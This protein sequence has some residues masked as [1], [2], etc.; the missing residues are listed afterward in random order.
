MLSSPAN[1]RLDSSTDKIRFLHIAK[2]LLMLLYYVASAFFALKKQPVLTTLMVSTL[3][4][5]IGG[6]VTTLAMLR[7]LGG[8]PIPAKSASLH[9][10]RM[11]PAPLNGRTGS[12]ARF[13]AL[14]TYQNALALLSAAKGV[15]QAVV[16]LTPLRV[17]VQSPALRRVFVDG[18]ITTS[19]F[20]TM[21]NAP[22]RYGSTWTKDD[23]TR[24]SRIV[25]LSSALNDRL[26]SGED[27]VG[28]TVALNGIDYRVTGVLHPWSPQPR[29]YGLQL[30]RQSFGESDGAYLPL[31]TALSDAM[32]PEVISCFGAGNVDSLKS[33]PCQ[34]LGFWVETDGKAGESAYREYL[35]NFVGNEVHAGRMERA[36]SELTTLKGWL[37]EN[38]V[39]SDD[40]QLQ[41]GLAIGFLLICIVNTSGLLLAKQLSRSSEFGIRRALGAPK[42][43]IF[44]QTLVEAGGIGVAG[45]LGGAFLSWS[46]MH[47]IRYQQTPYAS[48]IQLDYSALTLALVLSVLASLIAGVIP[49]WYTSKISPADQVKAV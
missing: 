26:F 47:G 9:Y 42:Q 21:F 43:A 14:M 7:I 19:D 6:C 12:E 27:S 2:G 5:G 10:P 1:L 3:A 25:V 48:L 18:V 40:V 37:T 11:D 23:D 39:V 35:A 31:Q 8:D 34:F 28:R 33:A 36:A 45:A 46:A 4:L 32:K 17:E 41:A 13:P 20:T 22:F 29:F 38:S 24:E 49:A 16:A 44:V 30:S 15:R